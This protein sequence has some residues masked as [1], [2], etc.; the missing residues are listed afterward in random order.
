MPSLS[1]DQ[2]LDIV[3]HNRLDDTVIAEIISTGATSTE[4]LEALNRVSRGEEVGKE[5]HHATGTTVAALCEILSTAD[6]D[7]SEPDER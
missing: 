6:E 5:T 4:L 1:H 3:G 7:W 2:V